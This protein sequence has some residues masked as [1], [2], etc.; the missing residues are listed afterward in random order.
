M[1]CLEERLETLLRRLLLESSLLFWG[2][3][4]GLLGCLDLLEYI[5][6]LHCCSER[7]HSGER[8]RFEHRT[9]KKEVRNVRLAEDVVFALHVVQPARHAE[10]RLVRREIVPRLCGVYESDGVQQFDAV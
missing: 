10:E 3:V 8:F 4:A 9:N 7:R 1:T 6:E 2:E 5:L